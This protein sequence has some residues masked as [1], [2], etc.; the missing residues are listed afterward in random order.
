MFDS[1]RNNKKI[2]QIFLALITLP[3]AFFGIDSY[4]RNMGAG[5]DLASVGDTK[6]SAP[7]FDQA[8]RDRQNQL[9]KALGENFKPEMMNSP[10]ARMAVLN[11]LIDQRLLML[12]AFKSHLTTSDDMLRDFIS[13]VPSLQENGQFSNER[14]EAVMRAQ[15]MSRPQFEAKLRQ[16]LTLQ[17]LIGAVSDTAFVSDSQAEAMLRVQSEERQFSESRVAP[18]QFADKVKIDAAT[19]QKYYD[20]HKSA[21]EVPEQIKAEFVVFSADT[22]MDQVSVSEAEVKAWYDGHKD[23][24]EQSEE[25]RASHILIAIKADADKEKAKAKAEEVLQEVQKSPAKFAEL[26][27]KYSEDTG[28]AKDGGDLGYFGHGMMVKAFEDIVFKQKDGEISG[29]VESDYGFHIIKLTGVKPGRQRPLDEVRVE[30]QSELK[31]QAATGKFAE[32]AEAFNNTVYEQSDSL[33]PAAD[34]FKLKIQQSVLIPK[35][36]DPRV[37]A[38]LGPLANE[39]I[40][41]ALFSDDAIKN[42]RNTA[43]VEVAANTLLAAR[44]LEHV[45]ATTIPFDTVKANVEQILKNQEIAA[46]AKTSG[47]ATLAELQKGGEDKLTWAASKSVSRMKDQQLPPATVQAVF[48]A[49]VQKLPAYAGADIGGSYVLYKIEKVVPLEKIDEAKRKGLQSDYSGIVAKEDLSAYLSGLR[50]RY[51]I[52][53]NKAR[54][55]SKDRQ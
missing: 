32:A 45:A 27:K 10:E 48:K 39:K 38:T 16:D 8:L 15:G 17:Q 40:L 42:K 47:E 53:I 2:V 23:R 1:V 25:R 7:E 34:K 18:E 22:L 13:K 11:T 33:Q 30:I 41:A 55:E 31:H 21:F 24:Y 28:S 19:V 51:K 12:E 4:V 44:V 5:N 36:P 37:A 20:E 3:F 9:R 26:A 14:Y 6:I 54:V 52:D 49:D 50:A 29:L 35:N 43:A 46:M